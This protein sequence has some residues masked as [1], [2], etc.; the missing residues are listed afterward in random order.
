MRPLSVVWL[1]KIFSHTVG[2]LINLLAMSFAIQKLCSLLQSH[3]SSLSLICCDSCSLLRKFRPVPRRPSVSPI[4]SCKVFSV[5]V[6]TSRS[7]IHLELILVQGDKE[8]SNFSFLQVLNQFCQH[9]LLK[10]L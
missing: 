6:F 4:P 1:V 7:L 2:F 5:S 9:N 3:L 8:G 10:R